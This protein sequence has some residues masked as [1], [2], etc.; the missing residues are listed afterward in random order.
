M[1]ARR[2]R[3]RP[4]ERR[5]LVSVVIPC[6]NYVSYVTEA[7]DSALSQRG[8]E[9]EVIVVDDHSTDRSVE[10]VAT[11]AAQDERVRLVRHTKNLGA[12]RTFNDGLAC[13][14]GEYVARLDAD[15]LL[16][17]GSLARAVAVMEAHPG[18]GL[19]YGHPLHFSG[20]ALPRARHRAR[21]WIVWPG[22]LWLEGRCRTAVNVITSPE[23]LMRRSVVDDV[24]GQRDLA[25]THDME[26][27]LRIASVSD[28]AYVRGADQAWHR[29]HG[30]SL[31][32]SLDP[33]F[34]D[35]E[36]RRD[37]FDTLFAW[38]TARVPDA[39][40]L[41]D[42][43]RQAL[44][45]EARR[46]IAHMTDR[47]RVDEPLRRRYREFADATWPGQTPHAEAAIRAEA[48]TVSGRDSARSFRAAVRRIRSMRQ[49]ARWHRTG[50][51]TPDP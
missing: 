16:T 8:V 14:N 7:I 46:N 39:S 6:F 17:P 4:L 2:V 44:A 12:V 51:F 1:K 21:R 25:H 37:A 35:L 36:D 47:G 13:V 15:D 42:L 26:M 31:S 28:V 3:P 49:Y 40:R 41:H 38:A 23:V 43:A 24:G 9:V 34:G 45:D 10:V 32:Q 33:A 11:V 19:V 48:E 29:E 20:P 27:W 5:P 18:V 30:A 22:A 50:V